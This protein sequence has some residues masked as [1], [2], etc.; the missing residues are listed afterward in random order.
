MH[1]CSDV[2]GTPRRATLLWATLIVATLLSWG[3]GALGATGKG[4]IAI[5]A[6]ISFWKGA[7]II[8]DFMALRHAPLLW[9]A[10]TLGWMILVWAIIAIA[11]I[12]GLPQ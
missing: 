12:K 6:L 9:R 3:M 5:L 1:P 11:Y 10:L 7:V 4:A 8:L 2:H